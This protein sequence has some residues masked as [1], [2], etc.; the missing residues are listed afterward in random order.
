M[1]NN[2]LILPFDSQPTRAD[3]VKNRALLLETAQRLFE[4]QGVEEVSMTAIADA[5]GVGKGTLYR[6]FQ[7]KSD[8]CHAL[9]DQDMRDLQERSLRRMQNH[10]DALG[11]LEWF[12][13]QVLLFVVRNQSF[14]SAQ[15]S[16]EFVPML[17]HPAHL[18]W[19]QTI[20]GLLRQIRPGQDIDYLSD[21][22]YVMLDVQTI[23][24][25]QTVLGYDLPRIHAGLKHTLRL[26][27][28]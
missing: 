16:S 23:R 26:L 24:F 17:G 3:A 5:A 14:L 2:D 18:W 9:L 1:N 13:E 7:N 27:S 10:R 19:R 12:T 22:L 6:H 8:L 11:N 28:C 15:A 25:Q 20:N 4:A 21:M